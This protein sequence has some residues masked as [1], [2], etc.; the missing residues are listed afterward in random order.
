[1]E[2]VELQENGEVAHKTKA[3]GQNQRCFWII[4]VVLLGKLCFNNNAFRFYTLF[5]PSIHLL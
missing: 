3:H 2:K 1:M 4:A 5:V